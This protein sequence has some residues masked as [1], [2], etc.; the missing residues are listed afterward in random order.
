LP[1]LRKT[2]MTSSS[3]RSSAASSSAA[4]VALG[5]TAPNASVGA[6]SERST[7]MRKLPARKLAGFNMAS[8]AKRIAPA[9][10]REPPTAS[11]ALIWASN[12]TES[13]AA[14]SV[15]FKLEWIVLNTFGMPLTGPAN[16]RNPWRTPAGDMTT[17]SV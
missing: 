2:K 6:P 15:T 8:R 7:T 5:V 4:V 14:L 16:W 1:S 3:T 9:V 12:A 17:E 13:E 11:R 10:S